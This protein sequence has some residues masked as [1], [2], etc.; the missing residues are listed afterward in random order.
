M[1]FL[2]RIFGE[3]LVQFLII[4]AV[5]SGFYALVDGGPSED[6]RRQTIEVGPGRVAQLHETF[7]RTWQRP[8]TKDELE[9]LINAFIKEEIFYREGRAMG[10]DQDD[11]VFRRRLQQKMEFLMEP[12]AAEL[13][14]SDT[15]LQAFLESRPDLF[16]LSAQVAFRQIFFD[17]A[18]RGDAA[19]NDAKAELVRLNANAADPAQTGDP[20]LLPHAMPSTATDQIAR[21]FGDEF[22]SQ[23]LSIEQGTWSGPVHST[24]G[25]HLIYVEE[26]LAARDA[27]L[28]EVREV[29]LREWQSDKRR[30][31]A[32]ERYQALRKNY[33]VTVTLPAEGAFTAS[34]TGTS[35]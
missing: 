34:T 16:K 14:A 26:R 12:S 17:P 30:S 22:A 5:V 28:D 3:P 18:K 24:F 33:D 25:L 19:T 6:A 9:G 13:T 21:S 8:P 29:V 11:T 31:I 1:K 4:G 35:N 10:L 23:L 2:R 20:T 27:T 32:E 15:E 7:S